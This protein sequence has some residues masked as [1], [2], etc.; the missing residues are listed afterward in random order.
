[1]VFDFQGVIASLRDG[2]YHGIVSN[3]IQVVVTVVVKREA[4]SA[5]HSKPSVCFFR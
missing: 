2:S 1:M 4:L 3:S 5:R